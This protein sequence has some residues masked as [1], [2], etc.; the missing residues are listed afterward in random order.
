MIC[1]DEVDLG[2]VLDGLQVRAESWRAT[3]RYFE[4]GNASAVI[5]ECTD[6]GEARVI[7][8]HYERI[9][10]SI[11]SQRNQQTTKTSS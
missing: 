2:Q 5:E 6:S 1:F 7:A 11:V 10:S 3:E 9:I 4:T 8:A